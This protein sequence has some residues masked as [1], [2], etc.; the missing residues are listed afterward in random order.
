ML[1]VPVE[2]H[3]ENFE[4]NTPDIEAVKVIFNELE[5]RR[6]TDNLVKTFAT[7]NN[8]KAAPESNEPKPATAKKPSTSPADGQFD[9]FAAPGSGNLIENETGTASGYQTISTT[10]HFYQFVIQK[11]HHFIPPILPINR[12]YHE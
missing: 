6:L 7:E 1:D 5:F 9:L 12:Y 11:K 3:E 2:F 10:D 4:L 8:S